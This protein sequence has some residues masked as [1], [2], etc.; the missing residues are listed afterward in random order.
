MTDPAGKWKKFTNDLEGN[1]VTV[2]EPDPANPTT[3]TLVTTYTY[4]W[5]KHLTGVSM[6]RGSTTQTRAFVYDAMG[7]MTSA[8][9]PE[10]GTV[11]YNYNAD[12]TL[13]Y[14]HDAKGQDTVYSYDVKKRV[15]QIEQYPTGKNNAVDACLTVTYTYD[16]NAVQTGFSQY[17][18]GRLTT[19]QYP[20]CAPGVN[21][22]GT[23]TEMYSYHPAGAIL[24]KRF[25]RFGYGVDI[26]G[27]TA[28]GTAY[29]EADYSYDSA[30]RSTSYGVS[31]PI[32][33][34][35]PQYGPPVTYTYGLD[36][37]G[38]PVSLS[39][40][41]GAWNNPGT[42]TTWVQNV[43]Y[44]YAGR[45]TSIQF[46]AG[47]TLQTV[48]GG[49]GSFYTNILGSEAKTYNVNGQL[50]SLTWGS[51]N[52]SSLYTGPAGGV[53]YVYSATQ[54]N[55]Q[56]TGVVDAISGETVSYQYDALKR[57]TSSGTTAWSQSYQ[58]DGFGNLTAKVL[59]GTTTPLAVD[60]NTNR[61]SGLGYDLNGN[62][63]TGTGVTLAYDEANRV[64]SATLVSGGTEFY[65]YAPDNKRIYKLKADGTES[66]TFYGARGEKLLTDL[67]VQMPNQIYTP[68]GNPTGQWAFS[69]GSSGKSSVW[70]GGRLISEG[71]TNGS[72]SSTVYQ[73]RLGTNRASGAKF[74]PYGEE[75]GTATA[76]DR[77]KFGTYNRDG[78]TGLDYADQRFYASSYG[79]FTK[80]D[81]LAHASSGDPGSWNQYAY[82]GGD[83]V[84]NSDSAG[85]NPDD[86]G[87]WWGLPKGPFFCW[88]SGDENVPDTTCFG[89]SG[90]IQTQGN[91]KTKFLHVANPS[92]SGPNEQRIDSV[93]DWI[94]G[95]VDPQCS[96]WLSG[97]G[98][99][100][101]GLEGDPANPDSVAIGHGTYDTGISAFT[102]NNANQTDLPAGYAIT[103]N[104][105]GAFFKD[106]L[107]GSTFSVGGYTGGTSQAQT[108]ILLH[109]LAHLLGANGFQSDFG[110]KRAG[111]QNDSLVHQNCQKTLNAAK[112]IP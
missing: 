53:Q 4:D 70:F 7:N 57:L 69:F 73:D 99:A 30:G 95:N 66:W 64:A 20:V 84:N 8:T 98:D 45:Q 41:S 103:V 85:T 52:G 96:G 15:T 6:P 63:T 21:H 17:S 19:A 65:G 107:N 58:Y 72:M 54:N 35:A 48:Y 18:N 92:K 93:L 62:M 77:T 29:V 90:P 1:L 24:A 82:V 37:M 2:T 101:S 33:S 108:F 12:N 88:D 76:N 26:D 36:S 22:G 50:S 104:D 31:Y 83:P 13:W 23:V 61:L 49:S 32:I 100:I 71:G 51:A 59:N 105:A 97:I 25:Q 10:N 86:P 43:Q 55:G 91:A 68:Q 89:N 44:D 38:R 110:D 67:Q 87:T 34:G 111:N 74:L 46:R 102:G 75:A 60:A 3:A 94:K 112:N 42:D 5:M 79:R 80:P 106:S 27:V 14:K 28:S 16:T 47:R 109:E 11:S 9:N 56:I 78:F 81:P 40:N 39:D